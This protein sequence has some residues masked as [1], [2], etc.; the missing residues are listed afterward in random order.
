MIW[1]T[2]EMIYW[3]PA[4]WGQQSANHL[5]NQAQLP[6]ADGI[7]SQKLRAA[8]KSCRPEIKPQVGKLLQSL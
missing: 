1:R 5:D 2:D 7:L 8:I 6:S 4:D 3:D